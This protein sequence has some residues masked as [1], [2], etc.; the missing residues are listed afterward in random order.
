M[1]VDACPIGLMLLMAFN[2]LL[3]F[4][5]ANN[6]SRISLTHGLLVPFEEMLSVGP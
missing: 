6:I 1:V 3:W 4:I 5:R 2:I